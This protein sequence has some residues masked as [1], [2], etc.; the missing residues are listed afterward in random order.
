MHKIKG[1]EQKKT[2]ESS[3]IDQ[4]GEDSKIGI[5]LEKVIV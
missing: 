3:K 1:Y 2:G 4:L 5:R